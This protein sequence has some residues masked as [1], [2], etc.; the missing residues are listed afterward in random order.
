M[1]MVVKNVIPVYKDPKERLI[2]LQNTYNGIQRNLSRK[3]NS[4]RQKVSEK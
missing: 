3:Q 4:N 1:Q 2:R